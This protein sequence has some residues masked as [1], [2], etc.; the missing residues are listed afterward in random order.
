MITSLTDIKTYLGIT[1]ASQDA[2][3]TLLQGSCESYVKNI[4]G[5]VE[6]STATE[7]VDYRH[8]KRSGSFFVSRM[9]VTAITKIDASTVSLTNGT[10]WISKKNQITIPDLWRY[11]ASITDFDSWTIEYTAGYTSGNMPSD[12]KLAVYLLIS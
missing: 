7:R 10:D 4:I 1:D 11:L 2:R 9:P 12:L 8:T 5:E 6:Q 3:L